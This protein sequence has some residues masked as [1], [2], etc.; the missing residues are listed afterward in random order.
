MSSPLESLEAGRQLVELCPLLVQ[1]PIVEKL[2][3]SV[4]LLIAEVSIGAK[5]ERHGGELNLD[6]AAST[7]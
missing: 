5:V 7:T 2:T 1:H 4:H 6:T 3:N